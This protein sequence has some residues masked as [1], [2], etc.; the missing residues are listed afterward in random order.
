[1]GLISAGMAAMRGE[2]GAEEV[3]LNY[4]SGCSIASLSVKCLDFP[5]MFFCF[6]N[7]ES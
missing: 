4:P 6:L 7:S 5:F 1:M 2:E 3:R